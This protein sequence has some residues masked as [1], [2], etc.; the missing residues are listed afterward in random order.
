MTTTVVDTYPSRC[1]LE[2]LSG[3]GDDL[4]VTSS[5]VARRDRRRAWRQFGKETLGRLRSTAWSTA[6]S[7]D[8]ATP[9]SITG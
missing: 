5:R 8:S 2:N 6:P 3:N 9:V 7:T 1:A 4:L